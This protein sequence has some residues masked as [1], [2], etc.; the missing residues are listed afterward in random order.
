[1]PADLKALA[2]FEQ[3]CSIE[4][5]DFDPFVDGYAWEKVFCMYVAD[6]FSHPLMAYIYHDTFRYQGL[7][8]DENRASEHIK[9]L[10]EKLD[11]YDVILS[12]QRYLAGDVRSPLSST[13]Q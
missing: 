13:T 11:V 1:M 3:A 10:E 12:K 6:I 9:N 8:T 4:L 2:K 5:C 7:K